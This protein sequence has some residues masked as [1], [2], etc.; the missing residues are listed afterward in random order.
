EIGPR[1]TGI[2]P[3]GRLGGAGQEAPPGGQL[4]GTRPLR[5]PRF[6]WERDIYLLP[7]PLEGE[8]LGVRGES[9]NL[10]PRPLTPTLS[11]KG[12]GSRKG[13][14]S[15]ASI[16]VGKLSPRAFGQKGGLLMQRSQLRRGIILFVI[17]WGLATLPGSAAR[18]QSLF[19]GAGFPSPVG[20][21][22][23]V[24]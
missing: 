9:A 20:N 5:S 18:A 3:C 8:G 2:E 16:S 6:V 12:R 7:S 22:Q 1:G 15:I 4:L 24:Q 23:L 11:H 10:Y 19:P 14:R 21:A 17:G 13:V